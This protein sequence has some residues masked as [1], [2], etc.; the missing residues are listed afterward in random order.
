MRRRITL[1][2]LS[3]LVAT[4]LGSAL[5][6]P[7]LAVPMI[8]R[9]LPATLARAGATASWSALELSWTGRVTLRDVRLE[10]QALASRFQATEAT[11]KARPFSLLTKTPELTSLQVRNAALTID[12]PGALRRW[13]Q[14]RLSSLSSSAESRP[15]PNATADATTALSADPR[16]AHLLKNLPDVAVDQISLDAGD[17]YP[18]FSVTLTDIAL[19]S[20]GDSWEVSATSELPLLLR[21]FAKDAALPITGTLSPAR[22]EA[23]LDAGSTNAPALQLA[24]PAGSTVHVAQIS[25]D[26]SSQTLT[27]NEV[28][29]TLSRGPLA[30]R[31]ELPVLRLSPGS[32]TPLLASLER[33]RVTLLRASQGETDAGGPDASATPETRRGGLIDLLRAAAW[34]T[35]LLA[36]DGAIELPP[37]ADADVTGDAT[38]QTLL[39]NATLRWHQG[40]LDAFADSERGRALAQLILH[41]ASLLP[42]Y[43]RVHLEGVS[44]DALPGLTT[45]RTLPRRGFRGEYGGKFDVFVE[46]IAGFDAL[47]DALELERGYTLRAALSLSEGWIDT[48][49][50]ADE[51]LEGLNLDAHGLGWLNIDRPA[52]STE[53]AR[54]SFRGVDARL[55]ASLD[56]MP[57][58]RA[59]S[60]KL[61]SPREIAC[62]SLLGAVPEAL[63]GV[64]ANARI[65][66]DVTPALDLILAE[67]L[68]KVRVRISG[69]EEA[70]CRFT[71]LRIPYAKRAQVAF[72]MDRARIFPARRTLIARPD[73]NPVPESV[74]PARHELVG[75]FLLFG[76]T[77]Q[78]TEDAPL[79]D[80]HRYRRDVGWLNGPFIKKVEEGVSEDANI[81]VGPGTSS[82]VPL[83]ELP[84]YVGGAMYLSEDMLF[85]S[86]R[87]LSTALIN[88]ALRMNISRSRYVYGGSTLTQQLV[89]NLFLT[90]DKTLSRKIQ[91]VLI[92]WRIDEIV[93]KERVLE[94]YLNVIEFAPDV[95]G[96]GPAARFYFEK[97]ARE[98][99]PL[100][101]I[102]LANLKPAPW[103][104]PRLIRR[105]RTPEGGW[106]IERTAEIGQRLVDY[107]Y[108]T[109]AQAAAL[110]PY[111]ISW[112]EAR[113]ELERER[114]RQER[115][116][117]RERQ[118]RLRERLRRS[119]QYPTP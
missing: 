38:P 46:A 7:R 113:V 99:T 98:L 85:Y 90:R 48:E 30:A 63:L 111:V 116:A 78:P 35:E 71:G 14:K 106:W 101:A 40:Q 27:L 23:R 20:H 9:A 39:Q 94:L 86:N 102:F 55:D 77:P 1:I 36:S 70:P 31:A 3:L 32:T 28:E 87:A 47:P 49:A 34:A 118:Q 16:V 112:P 21:S 2:T 92:G 110:A 56:L 57:G 108:L 6:L 25:L 109:P 44:L 107:N 54:V 17:A 45:Q 117:E 64:V 100:E 24:G 67:E 53:N 119:A 88:R 22:R 93:P 51:R 97:D 43:A 76:P 69:F 13:L 83:D 29:A 66:G 8:E 10:H 104:G 89:K 80:W 74:P 52:L 15:S 62:Q 37:P 103:E 81:R 4:L 82:Y 41:P 26:G 11:L 58:E 18:A 61:S 68:A 72:N 33:P 95:Y 84:G 42:R 105:T 115:Q 73:D 91:E 96:I 50:L 19:K 79:P 12:D 59:L 5:F 65:E 60:L 75:D 114:Y